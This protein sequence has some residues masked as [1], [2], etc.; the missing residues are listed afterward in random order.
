MDNW[1]DIR[2]LLAIRTWGSMSAAADRLGLTVPTISRRVERMSGLL[3]APVFYRSAAGWQINPAIEG[4][5][6]AAE[7][8]EAA[9]TTRIHALRKTETEAPAHLSIGCPPSFGP[10]ILFPALPRLFERAPQIHLDIA[11]R[12]GAEG[13]GNHDIMLAFQAPERGRLISR[14]M[15][16]ARIALFMPEGA[17]APACW[18]GLSAEYDRYPPMRL[19]FAH[20]ATPPR[21]RV[22]EFHHIHAAM[23]T[24]GLAGPL[25]LAL[26]QADPSLARLPGARLVELDYWMIYHES[27]RDDPVLRL[28]LD[29]LSEAAAE[30]EAAALSATT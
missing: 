20:F 29:W 14:R 2:I 9:L 30:A 17:K 21:L 25:P 28:V 22:P 4:V 8:F 15:G 26:G 24:T 23:R 27:R 16:A 3:G 5:L 13:L 10:E 18:I 6:D 12:V 1:D 7:T 11:A 19:G